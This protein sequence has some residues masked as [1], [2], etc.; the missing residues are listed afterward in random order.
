MGQDEVLAGDVLVDSQVGHSRGEA[1]LAVAKNGDDRGLVESD[2][3][4]RLK[5]YRINT[6]GS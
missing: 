5:G 2:P 3:Q 1:G 4:L 6:R